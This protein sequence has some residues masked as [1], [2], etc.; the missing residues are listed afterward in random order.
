MK[1]RKILGYVIICL[2]LLTTALFSIAYYLN[3]RP[4]PNYNK[5]IEIAGL[6]GKV[7]VYRD[8]FAIPHIFADNEEDLY[9]AVGYLTAQ[10]R[11]WQMDLLRRVTTGR[12]SEI[13]GKDLIN[14]DILMRSLRITE[15]SRK[16]LNQTDTAIL[17][18]L[19]CYAD[20][21]NQFI[22]SNS[23]KLPVEFVIL[24]Y[25][26][27]PWLPEHSINL[28]GY[29][30]WDL[31][32][33]WNAEVVLHK[34]A[35]K[36]RNAQLT[37]F[38]P[39][40]D[41]TLS[42]IYKND[43]IAGK[44]WRSELMDASNKIEGLGLQVFHGSN[45]WVVGGPKT[46][47]GRP[48][49]A[50]DMHLGFNAPGVWYQMHQV[51]QGKL[52]VTGVVLPGQPFVV[53]GHNDSVAWGLTNVMNDDID[54]YKETL[55]P[56]D[57]NQ[58]KLNGQW[59]DM[60]VKHEKI[61]VKGGDTV[62]YDIKFTH[63]GPMVSMLKKLKKEQISMRWMGNE[64]SNELRSVCLLNRARNW[65]DFCNAMKTFIAISQN[66][67][68]ADTKG[69]IGMY[70][71]AG[72]PLRK[73]NPIEVLPGETSEYDW[74]G[75]VPFE[76]LPHKHNPV[77][78][79]AVSANNRTVDKSYPF[80]ISNWFDLPFR[81]D[82]I[83]EMLNVSKTLSVNDMAAIQT[84]Y[85]SK[86]AQY[87]LP[88]IIEVLKKNDGLN[89]SEKEALLT[90]EKWHG[91]MNVQSPAPAIFE[92]FF[93]NFIEN[94]VGDELGK[95]LFKEFLIDKI[96][97]RNTLH[98]LWENKHSLLYDDVT[99]KD[100]TEHFDDIVVKSFHSAIQE[101]ENEEGNNIAS[102]EW[103]KIHKFTLE[104]PLGKV[105]ILDMIFHLNRGPFETNGSFHTVAPFS[106]RY[107]NPYKVQSG[108]SQRH[109]Y[110]L[111]NWDNS[112]SVLPTGN[113]GVP[114]SKHYC[115]QTSMYLAG[116]YHRDLFSR[117]LIE[118]NYLYKAVLLPAKNKK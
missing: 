100:R 2:I 68:Y 47:S 75:I 21:V 115:D 59:K 32:G 54:F 102:W 83:T 69:N 49:L 7:E 39:G 27:E 4:V 52:N 26:P 70:C 48:M 6:N 15:K 64:M 84:D 55:N 44:D 76:K 45:N 116:K 25:K 96:L 93:T 98:N 63:R 66:A 37:D 105:K 36:L 114:S 40:A 72:I 77:E 104:H 89:P 99:T 101:L 60:L 118:Q 113:S 18:M 85:T 95:D 65:G 30:S 33:S 42:T 86:H 91:Q 34:I 81:F 88:G 50:N 53:S 111:G 28:I 103:G 10:D 73:G 71:C 3:N 22:Q 29:I 90:I 67:A 9:R 82:R 31:N 20:G 117:K 13:F 110:D 56:N 38:I 51:V 92:V 61:A 11:L 24:G 112:L 94:V 5:N 78:N 79:F 35:A 106:Y 19:D 16:V 41:T 1:K 108:A 14:T 80:Y 58:Y 62:N 46:I 97:V 109:I 57:S 23:H 8:S 17:K 74:Q 87:Y 107:S 12:L 43:E